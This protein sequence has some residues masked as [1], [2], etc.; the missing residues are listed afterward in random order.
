MRDKINNYHVLEIRGDHISVKNE[1]PD[2]TQEKEREGR[3]KML[4][5]HA[6]DDAYD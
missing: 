2:M 3:Q 1:K 6:Y 5:L 4:R